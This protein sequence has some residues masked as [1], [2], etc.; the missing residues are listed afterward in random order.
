MVGKIEK[1]YFCQLNGIPVLYSTQRSYGY[2]AQKAKWLKMNHYWG[3][4]A[5]V[6]DDVQFFEQFG[7]DLPS[8]PEEMKFFDPRIWTI[9]DGRKKFCRIAQRL[10]VPFFIDG[11]FDLA[12]AEVITFP[13]QKIVSGANINAAE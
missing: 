5:L 12:S 8:F 9:E 7:Y 11:T 2:H 6:L 3:G 4:K 13:Q 10:R 1:V